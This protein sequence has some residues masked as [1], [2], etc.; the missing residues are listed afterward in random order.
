VRLGE[1]KERLLADPSQIMQAYLACA[2]GS[3]TRYLGTR[4]I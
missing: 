1:W 2:Q 4:P 3:E